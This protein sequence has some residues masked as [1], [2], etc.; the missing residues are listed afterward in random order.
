M[1]VEKSDPLPPGRYWIVVFKRDEQ[2]WNQ[3][4]EQFSPERVKVRASAGLD[5][6]GLL[7]NLL[8]TGSTP[9]YWV[10][11]DV[12][13]PVPWIGIGYPT[14]V[15]QGKP[16]PTSPTDVITAPEPETTDELAGKALWIGAGV[17]VGL[18]LLNK[19]IK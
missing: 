19:L 6:G 3:W 18:F 4:I 12:L 9:G 10:Q 8:G 1:A 11:F 2:A 13:E 5:P 7:D 16:S 17:V 15:E 14:I